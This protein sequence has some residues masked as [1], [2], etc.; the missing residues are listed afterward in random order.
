MYIPWKIL[1]WTL[2]HTMHDE[3]S[4]FELQLTRF[5]EMG[6]K[7]NVMHAHVYCQLKV[8]CFV[9][10]FLQSAG[11]NPSIIA[12]YM[13]LN[14]FLVQLLGWRHTYQCIFCWRTLPKQTVGLS[15]SRSFVHFRDVI[16][17]QFY[18]GPD[19]FVIRTVFLSVFG[20]SIVT[21]KMGKSTRSHLD[22][23]ALLGISI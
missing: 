9:I 3:Q 20:G 15:Q 12:I 22:V 2:M 23:L 19:R 18:V 1:K 7:F 21:V 4:S 11:G 13:Q 16:S 14:A 17:Q 6:R 10:E 5:T 8:W